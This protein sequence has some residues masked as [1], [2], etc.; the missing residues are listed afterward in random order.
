MM[1]PG[2]EPRSPGQLANTLPTGPMSQSVITI[3]TQIAFSNHDAICVM[4]AKIITIIGYHCHIGAHGLSFFLIRRFPSFVNIIAT[5]YLLNT[6]HYKVRIKGIVEQSREWSST[7]PNTSVQQLLK[8]EP[9]G[10][11]Q[12]QSP[13]LLSISAQNLK[14]LNSAQKQPA[15]L[16]NQSSKTTLPDEQQ[17]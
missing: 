12:L 1:R 14:Y 16:Q 11:P 17:A 9:S 4:Y 15:S 8:R 10:C 5:S 3:Q 13:T 7:L 6:Q 2:I